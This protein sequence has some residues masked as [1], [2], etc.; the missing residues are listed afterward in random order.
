MSQ[1]QPQPA[2]VRID[3]SGQVSVSAPA[4]TPVTNPA[5]ASAPQQQQA[6]FSPPQAPQPDNSIGQTLSQLGQQI[7]ALPE[8]LVN[9]LRESQTAPQQ[10]QNSPQTPAQ[11]AQAQGQQTQ[12][13]QPA[14]PAQ[15]P[16][17]AGRSG[18]QEPGKLARWWFG[19]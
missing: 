2:Q 11:P 18:A 9:S 4:G 5:P 12:P 13:A 19:R 14:Q 6:P 7:A 1:Q 17:S 8:Q 10:H 3:D 16:S 15:T